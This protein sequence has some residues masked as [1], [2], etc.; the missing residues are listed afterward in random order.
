MCALPLDELLAQDDLGPLHLDELLVVI[1]DHSLLQL[2]LLLLRHGNRVGGRGVGLVVQRA[3]LVGPH[4]ADGAARPALQL[5]REERREERLRHALQLR[6]EER[7]KK[8]ERGKERLGHTERRREGE[9]ERKGGS[10]GWRTGERGRRVERRR[11][12]E[13]RR[14]EER[15]RRGEERGARLH[16]DLDFEVRSLFDLLGLL[17]R[18]TLEAVLLLVP[19]QP[20]QLLLDPP[21]LLPH[22]LAVLLVKQRKL[23]SGDGR[24]H[25]NI[26]TGAIPILDVCYDIHPSA[27]TPS[28]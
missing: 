17:L 13:E 27:R 15:R 2:L 25:T 3:E 4:V 10:E 28:T 8:E 16:A 18:R 12:W 20:P 14:G 1:V 9:E 24:R 11:G 21:P 5:R 6:R 23:A 26:R 7:G 19:L 22:L